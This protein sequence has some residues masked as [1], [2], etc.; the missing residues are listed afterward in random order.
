MNKI[1]FLGALAALLVMTIFVFFNYPASWRKNKVFV[2]LV[3][4]YQTLGTICGGIIFTAYK[5][6]PNAW[7]KFFVSRWGTY[8][9]ITTL[10]LSILFGLRILVKL[11][12]LLV[13][14]ITKKTPDGRLLK[15]AKDKRVHSILFVI[16]AFTI[17]TVGFI[18]INFLHVKTYEVVCEKP[19]AEEELNIL[20]LSDVHAGAGTWN[21][22]YG[23]MHDLLFRSDADV[24]F[25][26]GDIF[27]ETTAEEDVEMLRESL[28]GLHPKY[29]IYYI[30]GNH[31]AFEDNLS[32][33]RMEE[34]GVTVLYDEMVTIG[35]VQVIGR[36]DPRDDALEWDELIQKCSPDPE[37]PLIVLTH[38]PEEFYQISKSGADL[39]LAGHTHGFNIP[40]FLG[41]NLLE[42][43]YYG[44]KE[45]G[46]MSAITTSGVSAWGI[47]YK[48]PAKSE[49]VE[50]KL[51]FQ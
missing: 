6:L 27:D 15:I 32:G 18:R 1:G 19:S 4:I 29:G 30:Y 44:R 49:V 8:Y 20:F 2:T 47:H 11:A 14:K 12:Y 46:S 37:K 50:V 48:W 28:S 42:D 10:L 5:S 31:D 35:D 34:M 36:L 13:L 33:K 41:T 23:K 43:M 51:K 17:C 9:Y 3:I 7:M 25:L 21:A 22:T 38:R 16:I 26:G 39:S 45:Y 24:I 40:Q